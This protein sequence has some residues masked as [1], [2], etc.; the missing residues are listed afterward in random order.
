MSVR[1]VL[2]ACVVLVL[3]CGGFRGQDSDASRTGR[4]AQA[5]PHYFSHVVEIIAPDTSQSYVVVT[6]EVWRNATSDLRDLRLYDGATQVPYL[7]TP[8]S[9]EEVRGTEKSVALL[10]LGRVNGQTQFVLPLQ[11]GDARVTYDSMRLALRDDT[12]DFFTTAR[13]QGFNRFE[14]T[15]V[16]VGQS[17]LFKLEKEKLGANLVI[18]FK[19]VIFRYLRVTVP[20]MDPKAITGANVFSPGTPYGWTENPVA[21]TSRT[22]G[23]DTI[24]EWGGEDRPPVGRIVFTT[25]TNREFW[26]RVDLEGEHGSAIAS[27]AIWSI[28]RRAN[29]DRSTNL[30]LVIP[31]EARSEHFK[32][33]VHNGDDPPLQLSIRAAYRERRVYFTPSHSGALRLYFG[34]ADLQRP[35]YDYARTQPPSAD[36]TIAQLGEVKANPE[37]TGRPDQR[38]WSERHPAVLWIALGIAV[39]GLGAVAL[40]SLTAGTGR[41]KSEK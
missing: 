8:A 23:H 14:D 18:H 41:V 22:E 1:R 17:T 24:M 28:Q 6:P 12:P 2:L 37:Y 36:A 34:D 32:L 29:T 4:S 31:G 3:S 7:L 11:G 21:A 39:L 35:T 40:K 38:P 25:D 26:R 16:D 5:D 20:G 33:I 27:G 15:P 19:P 10:N 13:I 9:G 30:E